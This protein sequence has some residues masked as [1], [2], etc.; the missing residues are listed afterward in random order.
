MGPEMKRVMDEFQLYMKKDKPM[1]LVSGS[2]F[3]SAL[4][5][6]SVFLFESNESLGFTGMIA[7]GLIMI[8]SV[9]FRKR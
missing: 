6:G 8:A 1:V 3:A 5:F 4:F 9:I 2:I 7:S